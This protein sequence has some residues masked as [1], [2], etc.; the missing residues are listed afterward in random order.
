MKP[1]ETLVILADDKKARFLV[2]RGIGKGLQELKS[3]SGDGPDINV[4]FAD[5]PVRSQ[6]APG[7]AQHAIDPRASVEEEARTRFLRQVRDAAHDLWRDGGYGRLVLS[8]PPKTLGLLRDL[9]PR[10]MTAK[11]AV[12]LDKD[13]L[14]IPAR[15]L[16]R[17]FENH[18]VF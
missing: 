11:L 7:Q 16:P 4:E 17:F 5:R 1:I 3:L 15:D 6:G 13:F 9:L 14:K 10:D 8:A 12:D 18:I 2:N